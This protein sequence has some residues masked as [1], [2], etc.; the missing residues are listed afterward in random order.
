M[1]RAT[2]V[3]LAARGTGGRFKGAT[4][5]LGRRGLMGQDGR[6]GIPPGR[7]MALLGLALALCL[8]AHPGVAGAAEDR[9]LAIMKEQERVNHGF[10][11]EIATYRMV[12]VNA[13][14][15]R[16]ERLMELRL[17]E[18]TGAEGDKTLIVFKAP[19]DIN[20]TGLLTHQ[21][22]TGDDD[23]WLYLPALRRVRRIASANRSSS[24]VGSEFTYEDMV[25]LDLGKYTFKYLRDDAIGD[26][27]VWVVESVP[28]SKDSAY[29]RTEL[30]VNQGNHQ[31]VRIDFYDKRG[32]VQKTAV[33]MDWSK[34]GGK[35][36]RPRSIR[37]DNRLTKKST[38]L[39]TRQI[40]V[41]AGLSPADFAPRAL[42]Q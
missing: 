33:F 17:L 27:K 23:Q 18:G 5:V 22:M 40:K 21:N 36:W 34:E 19:A 20:G 25:P 4:P 7:S 37:M 15:D 2:R 9:G 1:T 29:S 6:T 8:Q 11:S 13:N 41:D 28:R 12:L 39:E 42:E 32:E 10:G 14:G 35:W 38:L 3:G 16:S 26:T 30:F 31:A 24:F